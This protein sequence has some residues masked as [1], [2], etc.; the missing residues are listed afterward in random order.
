MIKRMFLER[1]AGCWKRAWENTCRDPFGTLTTFLVLTVCLLLLGSSYLAFRTGVNLLPSWATGSNAVV[2]FRS[3]SPAQELEI[4]AKELRQRQGIDQ[5]VVVASEEAKRRLERHL[6]EWKDIVSSIPENLLPPS[7]EIVWGTRPGPPED[8]EAIL[9]KVRQFPK[10]EEVFYGKSLADKLEFLLR[11]VR[12][13]WLG[14]TGL[15]ALVAV[16]TV[17]SSTRLVLATTREELEICNIL[18]ATPFFTTVPFYLGSFLLGSTSGVFA[19]GSL[20]FVVYSLKKTLP[21]PIAAAL[22]WNGVDVFLLTMG[23]V[24]CGVGLSVLGS[25]LALIRVSSSGGLHVASVGDYA[26]HP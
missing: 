23:L 6:G 3:G 14:A 11:P 25:W 4:L 19:M 16:L 26:Q 2:Y 1:L 21:I 13:L 17:F 10:V 22:P 8:V 7:L 18:G 5:V 15:M 9:E 20:A 12:L 24:C